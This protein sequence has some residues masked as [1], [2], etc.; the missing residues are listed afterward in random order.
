[1]EQAGRALGT[2]RRMEEL[3]I[4]VSAS[5]GDLTAERAMLSAQVLPRLRERAAAAGQPATFALAD[6][7]SRTASW[8]LKDR[9]RSIDSCPFFVAFVG[10]RLGAPLP[11][12]QAD[13]VRR[14]P[15]LAD[16]AG[17]SLGEAEIVHGA[18]VDPQIGQA[19]G[20]PARRSFLYIRAAF[21]IPP[22]ER[23]RFLAATPGEAERLEQ[24]KDSL[25]ASRRP[26]V[27]GYA[28]RWDAAG[29][30]LVGLEALA[31]RL[32][33][34][35]WSAVEGEPEP[36]REAEARP[37]PAARFSQPLAE[38]VTRPVGQATASPAAAAPEWIPP[39][40]LRRSGAPP[41]RV[42][43]REA[44]TLAADGRSDADH[45]GEPTETAPA[46]PLTAIELQ[47]MSEENLE[48]SAADAESAGSVA[49]EILPSA[50]PPI[51]ATDSVAAEPGDWDDPWNQPEERALPPI[52]PRPIR[53]TSP[54]VWLALALLI[55]VL[56]A[57]AVWFL[58]QRP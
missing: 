18:L 53:R 55:V 56:A 34:D 52:A 14:Y 46:I 10:E 12:P 28:C 49:P 32:V 54:G 51:T 11:P 47:R 39:P 33:D 45:P 23:L 15:W 22:R 30:Q 2:L 31:D 27:D 17:A 42:A 50:I 58:L 38:P 29:R 1:M 57:L 16:L 43:A 37:Q 5:T 40:L 3:R 6:P 8:S 24:L 13:L 48:G 4:Y 36:E 21:P 41:S 20:R 25:R 9:L 19:G 7:E 26:L 35:L 44:E